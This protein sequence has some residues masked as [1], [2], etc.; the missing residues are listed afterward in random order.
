M[1]LRK[2]SGVVISCLFIGNCG[3][4][5]EAQGFVDDYLKGKVVNCGD[6]SYS[7]NKRWLVEM[8]DFG[9][10]IEPEE[11]TEAARMNGYEFRGYVHFSFTALRDWLGKQE[12]LGSVENARGGSVFPFDARDYY[13]KKNGKWEMQVTWFGSLLDANSAPECSSVRQI[14]DCPS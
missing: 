5:T 2:L 11:L 12:M 14:L 7:E 9:Y 10:K 3:I 1:T 8:K 6:F 13:S 4:S